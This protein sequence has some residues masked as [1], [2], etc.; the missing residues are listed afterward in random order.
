MKRN[1]TEPFNLNGL[2]NDFQSGSL[3]YV[4]AKPDF[5]AA[6]TPHVDLTVRPVGGETTKYRI[7]D[8]AGASNLL[9]S[10]GPGGLTLR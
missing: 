2:V 3:E 6:H 5:G 1:K 9:R 7:F 10:C 4:V 8:T